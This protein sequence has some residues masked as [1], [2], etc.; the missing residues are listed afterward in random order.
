[1]TKKPVE[2]TLM[3]LAWQYAQSVKMLRKE[4]KL[5]AN[6]KLTSWYHGCFIGHKMTIR[7]ICRQMDQD[8]RLVIGR[9]IAKAVASWKGGSSC[10]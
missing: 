6:S 1:M 8:C 4:R 10:A 9:E 7:T 2:L 5:D 3:S